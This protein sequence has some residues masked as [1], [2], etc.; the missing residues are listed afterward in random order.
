MAY[1]LNGTNITRPKSF[2]REFIPVAVDF[3]SITGKD[4]RDQYEMDKE[5]F[6]LGWEQML[7]SEFTTLL[8]LVN[9]NTPLL[10]SVSD[11]TLSIP[12]QS[13]YAKLGTVEYA[14]LGSS[15]YA[16]VELVLT[17]IS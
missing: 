6:T 9:L 10:F 15:Y 8:N 5:V 16:K 3:K 4:T 13:V 2:K 12:E 14:I 17:R 11:G 7:N 1:L